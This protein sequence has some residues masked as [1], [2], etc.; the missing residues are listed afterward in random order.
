M[1]GCKKMIGWLF[2]GVVKKFERAAKDVIKEGSQEISNLFDYKLK[3]LADQ[4]DYVS[5]QRLQEIEDLETQTKVDIEKLLN[6]A[7]DK[8]KANLQEINQLR[9]Q[10]IKDS[11]QT[12]S[13][14]NFYLENRIN[15]LSLAVMEA[16]GGVDSSL[17]RVE[18]LENQLFVDAS[19]LI[20]KI[21]EAIDGKLEF[22]RNELKRHLHHALP[23]P[24]DKCR[25]QLGIGWK[26]GGSIS[27]MQLYKLNQCYELSKLNKNTSIDQV[28]ETYGQLQHNAAMMAALVRKSP[29]LRRRAIEDWM[30][31]G[32]LCEFWRSTIAD[33]TQQEQLKLQASYSQQI[34][35]GQD[36]RKISLKLLFLCVLCAS[37]VRYSVIRA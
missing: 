31:Y 26:F 32:L 8:V 12:I 2:G 28:L 21:D 29:E 7:N 11:Q 5:Q 19:Q 35:K 25:Q 15:Q 34:L 18:N 4:F 30:K 20:D 9:E 22:I 14:T 16:I 24:L 33:Y 1:K 37:V 10:V 3:P 6:H 17:Q 23:N 13:Q 36:L 27:D